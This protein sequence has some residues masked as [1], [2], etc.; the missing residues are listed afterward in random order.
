MVARSANQKDLELLYELAPDVPR[1]ILGDVTRCG[2]IVLNLV[3]NAVKFTEHGQ[4]M[5][6]VRLSQ[7]I[8]RPQ[9][10]IEVSDTGI[11]IPAD[12]IQKFVCSVHANRC[13]DPRKYGGTGLGLAISKRLAGM[14]GGDIQFAERTR[15]GYLFHRKY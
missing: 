10:L 11:G 15:Q 14:M 12:R 7:Q 9:L 5:V 4:V 8:G 3:S 13:S 2:Q 1:L 6:S